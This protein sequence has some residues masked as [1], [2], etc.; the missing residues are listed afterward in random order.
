MGN[1]N[2]WNCSPPEMTAHRNEHILLMLTEK[3]LRPR[4]QGK[5][6][7]SVLYCFCAFI[8]RL[9]ISICKNCCNEL[10]YLTV[11]G[12]LTVNKLCKQYLFL[13]CS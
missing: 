7:S 3:C 1:P 2:P 11:N 9:N 10:I 5:H 6:M 13:I 12:V 8:V 4:V